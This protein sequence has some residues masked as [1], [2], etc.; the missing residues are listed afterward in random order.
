MSPVIRISNRLSSPSIKP[1]R[2]V[3]VEGW[4]Q[5]PNAY[6]W[7][8]PTDFYETEDT[9]VARVEVAGMSLDDFKVSLER[10]YL[11]ISGVRADNQEKRAYHQMEIRFGEFRSVIALPAPVD[12]DKAEAV[13]QDGFLTILLPKARPSKIEVEVKE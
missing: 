11:I 7:T 3:V 8:P 10:D 2:M 13:Y 6:A 4:H 9:Y 5:H 12:V 1:S